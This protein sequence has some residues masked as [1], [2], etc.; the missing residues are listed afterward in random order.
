MTSRS[1]YIV[2]KWANDLTDNHRFKKGLCYKTSH[3]AYKRTEEME[4]LLEV[5]A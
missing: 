1:S 2:A 4:K 3:E 5:E